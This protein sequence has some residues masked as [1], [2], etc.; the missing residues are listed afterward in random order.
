MKFLPNIFNDAIPP[1]W[2][3]HLAEDETERGVDSGLEAE[4]VRELYAFFM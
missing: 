3:I 1:G 2:T 4:N